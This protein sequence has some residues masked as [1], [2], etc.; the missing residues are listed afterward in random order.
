M[1][2]FVFNIGGQRHVFEGP[3]AQTTAQ[4]AQRWAAQEAGRTPVTVADIQQRLGPRPN[5]F[6][7]DIGS[8]A[9]DDVSDLTGAIADVKAHPTNLLNG[10]KILSA[11]A[12]YIPNSLGLAPAAGVDQ[13]TGPVVRG[14]NGKFG[15]HYD[16]HGVTDQLL[17]G[18]GLLTGAEELPAGIQ[19]VDALI[20]S[21]LPRPPP[22]PIANLAAEG[23]P[24]TLGQKVG[25]YA[26]TVEDQATSL[27]ILGPAIAGARARGLEALNR[28][29]ANRG[30]AHLGQSLPASVRAGHDAAA[31]LKSKIAEAEDHAAAI[32]NDVHVDTPFAASLRRIE[33]SLSSLPKANFDQHVRD[34]L[35]YVTDPLEDRPDAGSGIQVRNLLDGISRISNYYKTSELDQPWAARALDSVYDEVVNMADRQN[36]GYG[37]LKRGA[38][39]ANAVQVRMALASNMADDNGGLF[40]PAQL[41]KA[42]RWHNEDEG[43]MPKAASVGPLYD[44]GEQ[45]NRAMGSA[46]PDNGTAGRVLSGAAALG[47]IAHPSPAVLGP[48]AALGAAAI[49]YAAT[50]RGIANAFAN[51]DPAA[52][53]AGRFAQ[54]PRLIP[55][56]NLKNL[57]WNAMLPTAVTG[58]ANA[59]TQTSSPN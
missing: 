51:A 9:R 52:T 54:S 34:V 19:H 40:T 47:T 20:R 42:I 55:P 30:L 41:K 28:A 21:K 13:L 44:F 6:A 38:D 17:N 12:R 35:D 31:Y 45:A 25:G 32:V 50:G 27:P 39:E 26:K 57:G 11:V 15:T 16:P 4:F 5:Q 2:Q 58:A 7:T 33:S 59:P 53:L 49:P 18:A 46:Y 36:P 23:I 10:P 1:P 14:I 37:Q 22:G 3:D 43:D 24:L 29:V 8:R 56:L 48:V